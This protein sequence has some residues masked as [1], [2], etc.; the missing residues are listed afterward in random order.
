[1]HSDS[2]PLETSLWEEN[3]IVTEKHGLPFHNSP[4][5]LTKRD[6]RKIPSA[7]TVFWFP[8]CVSVCVFLCLPFYPN[9]CLRD[10]AFMCMIYELLKKTLPLLPGLLNNY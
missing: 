2:S 10:L 6:F 5:L 7:H 8:V 4:T 3:T 1:M 9:F